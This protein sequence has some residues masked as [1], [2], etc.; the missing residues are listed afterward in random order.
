MGAEHD[1]DE[2]EFRFLCNSPDPNGKHFC[3]AL[4]MNTWQTEEAD[5]IK[6]V[7]GICEIPNPRNG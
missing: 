3:E 2:S 1:F 4:T 6:T 5:K 7:Y